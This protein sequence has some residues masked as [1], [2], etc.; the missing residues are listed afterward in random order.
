[1]SAPA[2][3]PNV[4]TRQSVT[5]RRDTEMEYALRLATDLAAKG[6]YADAAPLLQRLLDSE[7]G[8][9]L[10][11][12]VNVFRSPR[13]IAEAMLASFPPAGL[14]AYRTLADSSAQGLLPQ[15]RNSDEAQVATVARRFFYSSLGD[16]A[17]YG[18]ASKLLN[19]DRPASALEW[20]EKVNTLHPDP[21]IP[22][23]AWLIDSSS[24]H[25]LWFCRV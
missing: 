2:P 4:P 12:G 18:Y 20:L 16:D 6:Q 5:A 1:M 17:A 24:P 10:P 8:I 22:K 15:G 19:A 11:D 13:V 7:P 3:A 21:S 9:V 25:R 23:P 14:A